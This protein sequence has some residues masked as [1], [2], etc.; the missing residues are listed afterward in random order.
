[1]SGAFAKPLDDDIGRARRLVDELTPGLADDVSRDIDRVFLCATTADAAAALLDRATAAL[2]GAESHVHA[3]VTHWDAD[4][5]DWIAEDGTL[6]GRRRSVFVDRAANRVESIAADGTRDVHP[7]RK[8]LRRRLVAYCVVLVLTAAGIVWYAVAP[9]I[10][11]YQ[12]GSVLMLP[13]L[14]WLLIVLGLKLPVTARWVAA[15]A[16]AAIGLVGYLSV[17][18]A[19][20]WYWGKLAVWPLVIMVYAQFGPGTSDEPWYGGRRDGAWGPP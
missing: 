9:G 7:L 14:A 20:W 5:H 10:A 18:G 11:A 6:V 2:T 1:V 16:A 19:Q 12:F 8:P 3:Q 4:A 15:A 13:G 17:G